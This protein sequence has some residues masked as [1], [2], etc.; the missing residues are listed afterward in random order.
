MW[1][2]T[3]AVTLEN[4]DL[5]A[6]WIMSLASKGGNSEHSYLRL[7]GKCA[8]DEVVGDFWGWLEYWLHFLGGLPRQPRMFIEGYLGALNVPNEKPEDFD[9][10]FQRSKVWHGPNMGELVE[11]QWRQRASLRPARQ[12]QLNNLW[13]PAENR[14]INFWQYTKPKGAQL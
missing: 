4:Y 10:P 14:W 9:P 5:R 6:E 2:K 11:R 12:I 13:V 1:A 8:E 3:G 7:P